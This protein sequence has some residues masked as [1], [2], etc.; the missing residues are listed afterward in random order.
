MEKVK[1]NKDKLNLILFKGFLYPSSTEDYEYLRSRACTS[2]RF[3]LSVLP[4]LRKSR[5]T[6]ADVK[7]IPFMQMWE[8][9][10][11]HFESELK[12][13]GETRLQSARSC[14]LLTKIKHIDNVRA[15]C[16]KVD[17]FTR[18]YCIRLEF[19]VKERKSDNAAMVRATFVYS[20]E[21]NNSYA[22]IGK[23]NL[24]PGDES[25]VELMLAPSLKMKIMRNYVGNVPTLQILIMDKAGDS[26]SEALNRTGVAEKISKKEI[27]QVAMFLFDMC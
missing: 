3:P 6:K 18:R 10:I 1:A 7:L 26:W 13:F 4:A 9:F 24:K 23:N 2:Y 27:E 21:I 22:Y 20:D 8:P 16:R 5:L 14:L 17:M 19:Q 25:S 15:F 11:H 12:A